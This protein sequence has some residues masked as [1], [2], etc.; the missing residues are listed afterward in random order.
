M[1]QSSMPVVSSI[2]SSEMRRGKYL[3]MSSM[4]LEQL[5]RRMQITIYDGFNV[6]PVKP[7]QAVKPSHTKRSYSQREKTNGKFSGIDSQ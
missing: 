6:S 2:A 7:M 5:S 1:H 3:V 4:T